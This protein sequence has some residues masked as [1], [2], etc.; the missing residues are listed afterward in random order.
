[1]KLLLTLN[2]TRKN[3]RKRFII[4][5]SNLVFLMFRFFHLNLDWNPKSSEGKCNKETLR[6]NGGTKKEFFTK[7]FKNGIKYTNLKKVTPRKI[8]KNSI[9]R[10]LLTNFRQGGPKDFH[11]NL[12]TNRN[13]HHPPPHKLNQYYPNYHHHQYQWNQYYLP[14]LQTLTVPFSRKNLSVAPP[15]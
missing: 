12:N 14:L 2:S 5:G 6:I 10:F 1:M 15:T 7:P 11:W 4:F 13:L 8:Q 3:L 9:W